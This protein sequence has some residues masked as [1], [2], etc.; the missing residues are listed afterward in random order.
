MECYERNH[1][2]L[3]YTGIHWLHFVSAF[4]DFILTDANTFV[5]GTL[6]NN[7]NKNAFQ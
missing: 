7:L 5:S 6:I 3:V 4:K 2:L 1:L